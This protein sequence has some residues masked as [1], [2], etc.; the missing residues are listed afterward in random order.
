MK[1]W[2]KTM[3]IALLLGIVAMLAAC[4]SI[5]LKQQ[6]HAE[7]A[8]IEAYAGQPVDHFTWLGRYWGWKPISKEQALVWT[9]PD[10]GY[11]IKV[12]QPCED[13]RFA[14]HI[15]L[16]S[17]LHT[18]YSRGLDYVRVRGW[19]CPIEEIRPV[20]YGHGSNMTA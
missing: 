20:D 15:G 17:T 16:T 9:T 2:S 13:L 7:R 3:G 12:E 14:D 11:L 8:R 5:A 1:R 18:V 10:R 6:E 19:R 4:S